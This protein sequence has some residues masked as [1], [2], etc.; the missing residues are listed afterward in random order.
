[1]EINGYGVAYNYNSYNSSANKA[2]TSSAITANPA[3][4]TAMQI[5]SMT[6]LK[7]WLKQAALACRGAL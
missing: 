7:I 4:K 5:M 6:R 1:M 2:K 3:E